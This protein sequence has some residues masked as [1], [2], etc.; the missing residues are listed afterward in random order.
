MKQIAAPDLAPHQLKAV[1]EMRDGCILCGGV[2]TGKTRTA[3]AYYLDNE[4][5]HHERLIVITT[6]KKRDSLDWQQEAAAFGLGPTEDATVAG[7]ITVDSW[8]NIEKYE[9]LDKCFFIFDEQRIVGSGAWSKSF[10][11]IAR[12]NRW[13]LLSATP[14]DT[15]LDY[16]PVF[17]ANGYYKNRSEFKRDHV[18]YNNYT[19][20]PKVDRYLGVGKLVRLR[21]ELLVEMPY[22]KHTVRQGHTI[23]VDYDVDLYNKVVNKR[24]HVYDE[25]PLRDAGELFS[26]MRKVVNSSPSRV[27]SIKSLMEKHPKLIVFYNFDYELEALRQLASMTTLGEWNGHKHEEVPGTDSWVYLVQ[28]IAGSEGWNCVATDAMAFYSL[29]YSYKM[30]EQAQGR[31]DRLNS[32]YTVLSYYALAS[33]S[34]I[35][36]GV[37]K[38]LKSKKNFN[39]K[40]F[41][42]TVPDL[43]WDMS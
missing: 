24:W 12:Q 13:I 9:A 25:R 29:T 15:W 37:V 30:F 21:N 31:I 18:V 2:G 35:D 1:S 11:R 28:Y 17:L 7:T 8:N 16:I 40:G 34:S 26:V 27:A 38:A 20:F 6:A 23:T 5:G 10:I 39:E 19:K 22:Q 4:E 42:K 14:G 41:A 43:A 32:P 3:L 33:K 36:Q